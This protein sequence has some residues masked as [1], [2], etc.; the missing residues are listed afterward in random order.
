MSGFFNLKFFNIFVKLI[1]AKLALYCDKGIL[2]FE[3]LFTEK[4]LG[5][6]DLH[7]GI[8]HVMDH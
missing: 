8:K 7:L 6:M 5:G 2:R 3:D 4:H 1:I